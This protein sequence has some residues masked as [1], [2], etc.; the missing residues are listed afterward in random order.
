ML[1]NNAPVLLLLDVSLLPPTVDG[2]GWVFSP[3]PLSLPSS[4][5]ANLPAFR[6]ILM[7]IFS[8]PCRLHNI[9]MDV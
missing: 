5:P 6:G 3:P 2:W 1:G 7:L 8:D 4:S 9:M